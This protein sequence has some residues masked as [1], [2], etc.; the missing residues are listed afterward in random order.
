MIGRPLRP[1]ALRPK[2]APGEAV[3]GSQYKF[4]WDLEY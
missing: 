4:K 1:L 2:I 3:P